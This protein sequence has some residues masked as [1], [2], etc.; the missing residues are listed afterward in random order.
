[1]PVAAVPAFTPPIEYVKL[2]LVGTEATL[3]PVTLNPLGLEQ[4]MSTF[5]FVVRLWTNVPLL[6]V[7]VFLVAP[8]EP[9]ARLRA[10]LSVAERF[11]LRFAVIDRAPVFAPVIDALAG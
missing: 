8:V 4:L 1:V 6:P 7:A 9:L 5:Q 11:T 2:V 3:T 10:G